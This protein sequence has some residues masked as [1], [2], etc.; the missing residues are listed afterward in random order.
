MLYIHLLHLIYSYSINI[1]NDQDYVE[2]MR[3][4]DILIF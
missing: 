3:S 4:Y 2:H 1:Q